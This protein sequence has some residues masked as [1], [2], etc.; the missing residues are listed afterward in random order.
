MLPTQSWLCGKA[1]QW[2]APEAVA[3]DTSHGYESYDS[4]LLMRWSVIACDVLCTL[5]CV[6]HRPT[7][8]CQTGFFPAVVAFVWT[9]YRHQPLRHQLWALAV[10]A[11]QPPLLLIDH[12]HFQYNAISLG[13]TVR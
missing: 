8:R 3:L 10:I 13:L 12:G 6:R 2:F 5:V 4:K 9:Y 11:L 1:I 7:H